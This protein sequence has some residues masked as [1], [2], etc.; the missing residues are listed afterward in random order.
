MDDRRHP[1]RPLAHASC[2]AV[3]FVISVSTLRNL[4]SMSILALRLS[5][6]R[7]LVGI[8]KLSCSLY[9]Y[10]GIILVNAH[11]CVVGAHQID[12]SVQEGEHR[13]PFFFQAAPELQLLWRLAC[14][15]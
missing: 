15:L 7:C 6:K 9:C 5:R 1:A 8:K 3:K 2:S 4:T 13:L 11:S 14:I 10:E 12:D